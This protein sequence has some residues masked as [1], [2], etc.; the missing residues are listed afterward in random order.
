MPSSREYLTFVL[1]Q[2]SGLKDV[3][4]RAMMGEYLLYVR[5]RVVGGIYDD[6]LLV[7]PTPAALKLM[8]DAPRE[9]PYPGA[10]EM[11]LVEDVDNGDFLRELF[12]TMG[13]EPEMKKTKK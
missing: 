5:G 11:L 6:R 10:K 12:R 3:T 8:P 13:N 1:D 2:L 7:K 9:L 4:H